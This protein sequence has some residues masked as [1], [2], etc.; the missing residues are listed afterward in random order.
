[1][2]NQSIV[3]LTFKFILSSKTNIL[4]LPWWLRW[5]RICLQCGRPKL[6]P[7]VGKIPWR[8][9]WQPTP[10]FF[11]GE[12]HGQR[13]LVSYSLWDLDKSDMTEQVT[14]TERNYTRYALGTL[15]LI[16]VFL[17]KYLDI[18]CLEDL[19]LS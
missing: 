5:K 4:Q 19:L 2:K 6:D 15:S 10:T 16:F 18:C 9:K 1:M 13:S 11:P 12:S 7:W 17:Y 8:R 3:N 14:H